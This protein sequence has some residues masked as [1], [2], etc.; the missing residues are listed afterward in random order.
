MP[1]KALTAAED[2]QARK[3][4]RYWLKVL[5][6][7]L[8]RHGLGHLLSPRKPGKP[9][10]DDA[11]LLASLELFLRSLERERGISRNAALHTLVD[12]IWHLDKAGGPL[13]LGYSADAVVAR[14]RRKLRD[15]GFDKRDIRKLVPRKWLERGI[16]P[17]KFISFPVTRDLRGVD[18]EKWA[19][20][21]LAKL[22]RL[23]SQNSMGGATF[24]VT[25][26]DD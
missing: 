23:R 8:K 3:Q 25:E 20:R 15:G 13:A 17:E 18:P 7:D 16:D 19:S 6:V 21:K 22:K 11:P 9:E 24:I 26:S 1:R 12:G 5:G 10:H 14:L 2:R 4:A